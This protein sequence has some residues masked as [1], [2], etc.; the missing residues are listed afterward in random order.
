MDKE[1][2][3]SICHSCFQIRGVEK[4]SIFIFYRPC[5]ERV[6]AGLQESFFTLYSIG[7][8]SVDFAKSLIANKSFFP[9]LFNK[10]VFY[11]FGRNVSK[12]TKI[13]NTCLSSTFG[14]IF[15]PT[16]K[17]NTNICFFS[18][19]GFIHAPMKKTADIVDDDDSHFFAP[20]YC[21]DRLSVYICPD[22]KDASCHS[23][24]REKKKCG[25]YYFLSGFWSHNLEAAKRDFRCL[26]GAYM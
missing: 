21:K 16:K 6:G 1:F 2:K 10:V 5:G 24:C 17:K 22:C 13:T 25:R 4:N 14:L 12:S 9:W 3:V 26:F 11:P 19:F 8:V 20:L 18:T 23:H 7:K 15:G